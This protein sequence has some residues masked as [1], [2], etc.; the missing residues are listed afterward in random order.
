M[1]KYTY[2]YMLTFIH[3]QLYIYV[4]VFVFVCECVGVFV[5]S[6]RKK[7]SNET[8]KTEAVLGVYKCLFCF[9]CFLVMLIACFPSLELSSCSLALC[10]TVIPRDLF[11]YSV[12]F[13]DL[14]TFLCIISIVLCMLFDCFIL[15]FFSLFLFC[16]VCAKHVLYSP[17]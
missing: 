12:Y 4:R 1:C 8:R 6:K 17:Y 5:Y 11:L 3:I 16:R 14:I 2:K 13:L 7:K 15:F 9:L 10:D